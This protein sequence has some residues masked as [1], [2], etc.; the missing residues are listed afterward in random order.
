MN[1]DLKN[2]LG[3]AVIYGIQQL[4]F[5]AGNTKSGCKKGRQNPNRLNWQSRKNQHP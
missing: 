5:F 4:L 2:F 3:F 1:D